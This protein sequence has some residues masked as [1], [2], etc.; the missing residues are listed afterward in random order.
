MEDVQ[1]IQIVKLHP[2]RF[3]IVCQTTQYGSQLGGDIVQLGNNKTKHATISGTVVARPTE[4][5][6]YQRYT[7]TATSSYSIF[8]LNPQKD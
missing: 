5:M 8:S 2:M 6:F 7:T 4:W 3:I 1:H